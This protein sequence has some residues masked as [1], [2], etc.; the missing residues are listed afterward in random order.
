MWVFI[1]CALFVWAALHAYV[2]WRL[3]SVP[4]VARHLTRRHRWLLATA[5]WAS[6]PLA[7][8]LSYQRIDIVGIPLEFATNVW[9]GTLFLLFS[10][11]LALEPVTLG[12]WLFARALPTL[13]TAAV[14]IAFALS[15]I[16]LVQGLRAPVVHTHEITL[17]DLPHKLDGLT[18]ATISDLHLGTMRNESWL[19]ARID[20]LHALHADAILI[21]GDLVD[22]DV[23][24][25]EPLRPLLQTLHAP[26]GVWAVLGNHD[27]FGG[28][29]RSAQLLRDSGFRLLRDE[30]AQLAPGLTLAGVNDLGLRRPDAIATVAR[31]LDRRPDRNGA[32]ILLSHTPM[33]AETAATHGAQL[34]LSGHTHA[35]QLWP[36]GE[37]VRL[38]YP[39]FHGHYN[40]AGMQVYVSCGAGTWGPPMRLWSPGEIVLL[41]LHAPTDAAP[42][43]GALQP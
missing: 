19:R 7:H 38:V 27:T 4:L 41:R 22:S 8:W 28:G 3:G 21:V 6:F 13:R 10:A 11:L 39:L 15:G 14:A 20:Q 33:A 29:E 2:F 31:T 42:Q 30:C 17:P 26:L 40:I 5:L 18:L 43:G 9:M 25:V 12:G 34:M 24:R 32:T 23:R 16:A 36:F 1:L 35:G 37:L